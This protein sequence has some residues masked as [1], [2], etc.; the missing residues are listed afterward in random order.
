MIGKSYM[1]RPVPIHETDKMKASSQFCEYH[2]QKG[3][4][5]EDCIHLKNEIQ[6]LIE[7]GHLQEF[8]QKKLADRLGDRVESRPRQRT[9]SPDP[10]RRRDDYRR[11]TRNY[12]KYPR[13]DRDA[14][15]IINDR[16]AVEDRRRIHDRSREQEFE[17][18]QPTNGRINVISG[19]PAGGDSRN[20]RKRVE[21]ALRNPYL[22][23]VYSARTQEGRDEEITF[24]ESDKISCPEVD[25]FEAHFPLV[26]RSDIANHKD[27]HRYWQ[28]GQYFVFR[29]LAQY[30]PWIEDD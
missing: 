15:D 7:L 10:S 8:V 21:K 27:P 14:R 17:D 16:R 18:N 2:E 26:V 5:T 30:E 28:L 6:R 25:G 24:N 13:K 12:E 3:H 19:G 4:R 9:R 22:E 29:L 23:K 11:D 20:A 1:R